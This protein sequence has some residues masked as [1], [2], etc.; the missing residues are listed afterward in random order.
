METNKMVIG[1]TLHD[2]VCWNFGEVSAKSRINSVNIIKA[3]PHVSR[4]LFCIAAFV[5]SD[6]G[7]VIKVHVENC[8][9]ILFVNQINKNKYYDKIKV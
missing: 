6:T 8:N 3:I 2:L 9:I 7:C 5:I 1:F 4:S